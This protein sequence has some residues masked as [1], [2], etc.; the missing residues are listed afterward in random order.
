MDVECGGGASGGGG[1]GGASGTGSGSPFVKNDKK[2]GSDE[3]KRN[4]FHRSSE[5]KP[6]PGGNN[7]PSNNGMR[8]QND[9]TA[10]TG[11]GR[12]PS[13]KGSLEISGFGGFGSFIGRSNSQRRGSDPSGYFLQICDTTLTITDA[14]QGLSTQEMACLLNPYGTI[15]PESHDVEEQG[16]HRLP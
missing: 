14:S 11:K 5:E 7:L 15:R 1:G 16:G 12:P 13:R 9:N 4:S 8:N 3:S 6:L 10:Q 2:I